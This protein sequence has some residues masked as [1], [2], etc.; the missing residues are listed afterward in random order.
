MDTLFDLL[1]EPQP[2]PTAA[3]GQAPRDARCAPLTEGP[4]E[5]VLVSLHA[6]PIDERRA[7]RRWLWRREL[8]LPTIWEACA[9]TEG[10]RASPADGAA[11]EAA[12]RAQ[13]S[14]KQAG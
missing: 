14:A 8:G 12:A 7:R 9:P 2:S 5:P 13:W 10:P 6:D 1:P 3:P 4:S 11:D